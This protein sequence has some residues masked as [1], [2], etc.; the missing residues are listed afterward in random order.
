M[1]TPAE[2]RAFAAVVADAARSTAPDLVVVSDEIYE[3]I[4]YGGIDF[5][6]IGATPSIAEP[7]V[8]INGL[9]KAYSMTGWRIGYAAG[10]G[11]FGL[12]LAKGLSTLQSQL[13]TSIPTFFGPAIRVALTQCA[14]DVERMRQ[15]FGRRA[16]LIHSRMRAMPGFVCPRPTGAFYVFP[17]VSA[18]FGKRTAGGRTINSA[19]EFAGALLDEHHVAAV[20]GE[21][22]LGCGERCLRFSFACSERH[23]E[24]GMTRLATFVEGLR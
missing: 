19:V 10:S 1:Y 22:F 11:E 3:K 2:L 17:D 13:T 12:K 24:D 8:T 6:S 20:P 7:C 16:E 23:I 9:S 5:Y 21:D 15:A 18:H 4:V 14:A